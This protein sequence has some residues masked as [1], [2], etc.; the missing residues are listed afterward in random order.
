MLHFG[1]HSEGFL[2]FLKVR[3]LCTAGGCSQVTCQN[4]WWKGED[5]THSGR[6]SKAIQCQGTQKE[7]E[8]FAPRE[9]LGCWSHGNTQLS[10]CPLAGAAA[11]NM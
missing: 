5:S 10:L 11:R 9:K 2:A 6:E 8:H 4:E 7:P 1:Q 3:W